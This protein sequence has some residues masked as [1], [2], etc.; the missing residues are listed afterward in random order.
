MSIIARSF[1]PLIL[2]S[3]LA[4][5]V[6]TLP[7]LALIVLDYLEGGG[8]GGFIRIFP[9]RENLYFLTKYAA[10]IGIVHGFMT[11]LLIYRSKEITMWKS[12]LIGFWTNEVVLV[13]ALI[14]GFLNIL[15]TREVSTLPTIFQAFY[16]IIP[17]FL[18][19]SI[20]LLI[21]SI[22][23]G[24]GSGVILKSLVFEHQGE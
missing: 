10:A 6:W 4:A 5:I 3:L 17:Y 14:L 1:L 20:L 9:T 21:P 15:G 8:G 19:L 13:I 7:L 23:I 18:I 22:I 2:S 11:G 24:M 12:G 16:T